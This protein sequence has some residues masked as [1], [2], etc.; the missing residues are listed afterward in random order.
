MKSHAF[1]R[2]SA[3][4][5]YTRQIA[6]KSSAN[7]SPNRQSHVDTTKKATKPTTE[8][9]PWCP[10][11]SHYLYFLFA[12]TLIYRHSYPRTDSVRWYY[13]ATNFFQ[14]AGCVLLSYYIFVRFCFAEFVNFG[15]STDY[16]LRQFILTASATS[17]PGGLVML[18][19]FFAALHSW[20]N[21][22]AEMLRFG[23]RLFYKDWWNSTTFSNWYRTWNVVVH[24]WL[25]IYLYRDL[26]R[27]G[28]QRP[29]QMATAV[30]FWVSA[31]VHE[32][33]L[34]L[35][36]RF[37]YP[38]LFVFFAFAGYPFIY[39]K[40]SGRGWNVFIWV[41]LFTGWG[42]MMCLYSMEWYAR[43]NCQPVFGSWVDFFVPHSWFCRPI[44]HP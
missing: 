42:E 14:V 23:D 33:V 20:M 18:L 13:V 16:T 38:V 30:V 9:H 15:Q 27:F 2:T 22:F 34:I 39:L 44:A 40:G 24:D 17:L 8:T 3:E 36:L 31:F 29:R 43:K 37:V 28:P 4:E 12:P 5:V 21:A 7:S 25:Y 1:V 6:L 35:V 32:Y 11:F 26:Q 41:L 19:T 10:D